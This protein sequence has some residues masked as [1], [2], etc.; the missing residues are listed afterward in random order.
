MGEDEE[1][2]MNIQQGIF[3]IQGLDFSKRISSKYPGAFFSLEI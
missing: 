1:K 3:N 2:S